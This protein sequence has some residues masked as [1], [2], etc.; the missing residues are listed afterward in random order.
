MLNNF[1][2]RLGYGYESVF[3]GLNK[4]DLSEVEKVREVLEFVQIEIAKSEGIDSTKPL[5]IHS[6]SDVSMFAASMRRPS[7]DIITVFESRGDWRNLAK[8]WGM[9]HSEIQKIK[10]M[11]E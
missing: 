10:V 2:E 1:I 9:E 11:F 8:S 3:P 7:S 5:S 4:S 6:H